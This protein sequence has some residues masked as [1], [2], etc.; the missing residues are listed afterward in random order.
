M[1]CQEGY[2]WNPGSSNYNWNSTGGAATT[3]GGITLGAAAGTV[4]NNN[5]DYW[6]N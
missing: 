5:G 6:S 1:Q 3:P 2:I 4:T